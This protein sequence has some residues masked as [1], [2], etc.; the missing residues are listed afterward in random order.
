LAGDALAPLLGRLL[1]RPRHGDAGQ[2]VLGLEVTVEAA[3]G[4][5]GRPHQVGDADAL[6][7]ALP[8]Q[9][10]GRVGDLFAMAFGFGP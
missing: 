8:E 5:P 3:V 1:E 2:R 6:D 7:A 4:E 10:S 9:A